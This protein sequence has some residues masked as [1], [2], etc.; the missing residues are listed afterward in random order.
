MHSPGVAQRL[1]LGLMDTFQSMNEFQVLVFCGTVVLLAAWAAWWYTKFKFM[2][3][4][5]PR[6]PNEMPYLIPY[7]GNAIPFFKNS[8][9]FLAKAQNSVGVDKSPFAFTIFGTKFYVISDPKHA[10]EV[11]KNNGTLSFDEFIFDFVKSTGVSDEGM[12]ACYFKKLPEHGVDFPNPSEDPI[13]VLVRHMHVHQ[14]HPGDNQKNVE[15][16]FLHS[17]DRD[18]QIDRI[19]NS[20]VISNDAVEISL[21]KWCGDFFTRAGEYAYFGD[22]LAGIDDKFS[23]MFYIFDELSWQITY[24]IPGIFAGEMKAAHAHLCQSLKLYFQTRQSERGEQAWFTNAAEKGLRSVGV[25]DEDIATLFLTIYLT[26]NTNTRRA[27]FWML[28]FLL[29]NPHLIEA[30]LGETKAAFDAGKLIDPAYLSNHELCPQLESIWL[31]T[32]RATS[33][34]ASVRCVNKDTIIGGRLLRQGNKIL[35]P[36]RLLHLDGD[37]WGKST[38]EFRPKRFLS[39]KNSARGG[40]WRPFGGGSTLCTGRFVAEHMIKACVTMILHRFHLQII[41]DAALPM[42]DE[43]TPGLGIMGITQDEDFKVRITKRAL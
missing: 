43:C 40:S 39:K 12:Q 7:V 2:P 28:T 24:K 19:R 33:T 1:A 6:E 38:R 36:S 9:L 25:T 23:D 20:T 41:G 14:L 27:A 10:K 37:A 32:L 31:E 4:Q 16:R 5:H 26:I 30:V 18:L 11:D 34:G 15:K 29:Y 13:G 21:Y 8:Q 42:G 22:T 17:F 35:I 3:I